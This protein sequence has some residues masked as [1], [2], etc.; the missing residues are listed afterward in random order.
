MEYLF[1][2][3]G[4]YYL[5]S[6]YYVWL[7]N[8]IKILQDMKKVVRLKPDQPEAILFSPSDT[9]SAESMD[10][11]KFLRNFGAILS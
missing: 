9:R 3:K 4:V 5:A 7:L 8:V 11:S 10:L 6:S 2:F 1:S